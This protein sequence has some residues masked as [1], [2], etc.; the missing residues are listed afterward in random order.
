[1]PE[2]SLGALRATGPVDEELRALP[3]RIEALLE[4]LQGGLGHA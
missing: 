2:P 4:G 3:A 1:M